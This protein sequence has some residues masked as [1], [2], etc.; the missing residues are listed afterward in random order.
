L[1]IFL[2]TLAWLILSIAASTGRCARLPLVRKRAQLQAAN[3]SEVTDQARMEKL[4]Q[5]HGELL[6]E[7]V[8]LEEA[9]YFCTKPRKV[10]FDLKTL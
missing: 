3:L 6:E 2:M 10:R 1:K 7:V 8:R 4:Q 9:G 5:K